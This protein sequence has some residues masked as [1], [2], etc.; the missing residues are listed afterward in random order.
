MSFVQLIHRMAISLP[1]YQ[2]NA[3]LLSTYGAL[4][5]R[6]G[7]GKSVEDT[8]EGSTLTTQEGSHTEGG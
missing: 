4:C 5:S 2:I 3:S 1:Y 7:P 6:L 8:R